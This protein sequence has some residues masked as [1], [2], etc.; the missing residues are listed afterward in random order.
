MFS[1]GSEEFFFF[2]VAGF[3]QT[4]IESWMTKHLLYKRYS[5]KVDES[6][7]ENNYVIAIKFTSYLLLKSLLKI[8]LRLHPERVEFLKLIALFFFHSSIA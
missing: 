6:F 2:Y 7:I 4:I 3:S 5:Y 1:H 8:C